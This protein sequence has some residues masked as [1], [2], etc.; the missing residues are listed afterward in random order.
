VQAAE[1]ISGASDAG[2]TAEAVEVT[3]PA[4]LLARESGF[5]RAALANGFKET[6]SRIVN[7]EAAGVEGESELVGQGARH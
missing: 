5:F 3:L 6:H 7:Y 2:S 1:D 4:F